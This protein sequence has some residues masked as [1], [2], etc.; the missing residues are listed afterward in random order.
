M[1]LFATLPDAR[2]GLGFRPEQYKPTYYDYQTYIRRRNELLS[3]PAIARA[4]L[5]CG[6]I[7]W[8]LTVDALTELHGNISFRDILGTALEEI[9]LTQEDIGIIVGL[10]NVWTG[11]YYLTYHRKS[12]INS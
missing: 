9:Q 12:L 4:A 8:R 2:H 11:E 1:D 10:Y 3:N 5:K 7:I 6:G